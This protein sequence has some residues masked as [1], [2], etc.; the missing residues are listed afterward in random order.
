M[1]KCSFGGAGSQ[2][3]HEAYGGNMI[4]GIYGGEIRRCS[5]PFDRRVM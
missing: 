2:S 1:N 3:E 4:K 5:C